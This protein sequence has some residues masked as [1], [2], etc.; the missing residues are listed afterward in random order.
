MPPRDMTSPSSASVIPV[1]VNPRAGSA[2]RV[3]EA[4][5]A[6]GGFDVRET[7]PRS[8][9]AEIERAVRA[10]VPRIAVAGG[11]GSIAA[12]AAVL[13]G[14][15]TELAIVPGGTLNHFA[16]DLGIPVAPDE[17][18]ELARR[19]DARPVDVA[20]VNDRVFLNTS[21]VGA[22][23]VFVRARERLERR[24]GYRIASLFA[25]L[26]TLGRLRTFRVELEVEGTQRSYATPLVF[27]GVGERE[28]RLPMLGS[29]LPDGQRGLHLLIPRAS[30]TLALARLAL[31]AIV[32]GV[33][34]LSSGNQLDSFMV[35]TCRVTM[36]R[37]RGN[38][39]TDGEITPLMAPLTYRL[40][41]GAL[42]V[43]TPPEH[44][45]AE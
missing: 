38:V 7:D 1:F 11:D 28:L 2:E 6:S 45:D 16:R 26:G 21:S 14:T 33:R 35:E 20:R 25:A 34:P 39:A 9:T 44:D 40:E 12:A 5:E 27:V 43:V 10:G 18:A 3:R 32:R 23:V 15:A 17:A 13:A 8:L 22:Y 29:R 36:R 24:V 30:T 37:P 41:R 4:L 31:G 42:R 19:G